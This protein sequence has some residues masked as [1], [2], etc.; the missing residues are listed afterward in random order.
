MPTPSEPSRRPSRRDF[1]KTTGV[2]AAGLAGAAS[3]QRTAH[4]AGS[5]VLK[6]GLVGCGGRGTGAAANALGADPNTQLTALADPFPEKMQGTL[7]QMKKRFGDRVVVD[8][9]HCFDGFDG[10]QKVL[11]SGVDVILL[12]TPPHFRPIHL[13][14]AVK[15]GVHVFCEKPVAVDAPGIRS[16]LATCEAA[17]NLSIVSGLCWR[18]DLAVKAT[19]QKVLDGAIGRITSIQ[20]TY[21]T[22]FLW[23]R[24]R[25]EGDTEMKYQMRQWYYFTWL[26]G[27]HNVEQHVHSLDK[28]LWAMGDEPPLRAW[29]TGGRQVR[30]DP[31][32]GDI[33]DH[34]AVVYE[35][36]DNVHVHAYCRQQAGCYNDTSDH[37][38]GT[39][40][41][42][43]ILKNEIDGEN[44]WKYDG[45]KASMYDLEHVALFESIRSG[46]PIN[47][48]RYMAYSTM[49]AILGRMVDYTGKA[50]SWDEA[51]NSEEKL[52]PSA[53]AWDAAPPTV[54]GP[55]GRYPIAMPGVG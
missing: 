24:P 10:Y 39:K 15:A 3:L 6:V 14:A 29:G 44:P 45:P 40:G 41:H 50:I 31:I 1:L 47:N 20:E 36:P 51:I 33:Y 21:L 8:P 37:F 34:H 25:Q 49:L 2:A 22:G 11:D 46:K 30:T 27:D 9:E 7:E 35:Y 5:D 23:N 54:P 55:D 13:E 4:A 32:Y 18:Y 19:M 53:Y 48:G 52:A 26:S 28:A 43:N 42:A 38:F 17:K 12:A 16:V